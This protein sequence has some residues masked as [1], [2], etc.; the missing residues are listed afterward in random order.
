MRTLGYQEPRRA[1]VFDRILEQVQGLP[2]VESAA[3]AATVPIAWE[4]SRTGMETLDGARSFSP[5]SNRISPGYFR[6]TGIALLRGRD[7][8]LADRGGAS[9]AVIVNE[10]MARTQWPGEDPL[11]KRFRREYPP[12]ILEVVGVAADTRQSPWAG[13]NPLFVYMPAA[14]ASPPFLIL[15]IRARGHAKAMLAAVREIVRRVDPNIPLQN[16]SSLEER[17][18]FLMLP[19]RIAATLAGAFGA[20]GIL[21]AALGIYGVTAYAVAQRTREIGV[22]MALGAEPGQIWRAFTA[23]GTRL[24]AYALTISAALSLGIARLLQDLLYGVPPLDPLTVA[25]AAAA[26]AGV[27]LGGIYLPARRA[28]AVDPSALRWE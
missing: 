24:I 16:V 3:L 17:I 11:G 20:L 13:P 18:R 1:A 19:H 25:A 22:R 2:G 9:I 7:F 10:T 8:T 23:E 15:H 14:E 5:D 28:T 4:Y 21:L 27:W 6:T 26:F 12:Q